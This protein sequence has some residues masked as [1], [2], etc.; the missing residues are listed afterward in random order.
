MFCTLTGIPLLIIILVLA[1]DK[2]VYGSLIPKDNAVALQS[3]EPLWVQK[4]FSCKMKQKLPLKNQ[5]LC[6]SSCWLQDDVVFFV[7]VVAVVVLVLLG[8][9]AVFIVVLIQIKKMRSNKLSAKGRTSMQDLRAVVGLTVLLG[10]TWSMGFFSFGPGRVA[11]MYVFS[12]CNSLQGKY[13]SQTQIKRSVRCRTHMWCVLLQDFLCFCST[14]W[15]RRTWGNSGKLICA[16]D[17]L[18][19]WITQVPGAT[20]FISVQQNYGPLYVF[21]LCFVPLL[22]DWSRSVTVCGR[23]EKGNLI[24]SDSVASENTSSLRSSTPPQNHHHNPTKG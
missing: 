13:S 18:D 8:N 24:N 7:T 15:W 19:S 16:V 23:S 2:D 10:L 22:S 5:T 6:S 21:L 4:A 20:V 12:I 9:L 1:I 11:M 17:V 14:V 3:A